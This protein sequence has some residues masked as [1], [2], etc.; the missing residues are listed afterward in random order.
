MP[1]QPHG[2]RLLIQRLEAFLEA[3]TA[4]KTELEGLT[5]EGP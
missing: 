2:A 3:G 5:A 1:L 4:L